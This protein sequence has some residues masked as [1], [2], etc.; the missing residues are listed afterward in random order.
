VLP[1]LWQAPLSIAIATLCW[2]ALG[3]TLWVFGR[4]LGLVHFAIAAGC[5]PIVSAI[6][7]VRRKLESPDPKPAW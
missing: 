4:Q 3:G 7:L 2:G 6:Y 1:G 5:L